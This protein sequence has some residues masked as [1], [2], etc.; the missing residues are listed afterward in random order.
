[1]LTSN[2]PPKG[3]RIDRIIHLENAGIGVLMFIGG[4]ALFSNT[5]A[6]PAYLFLSFLCLCFAAAGVLR[7]GHNLLKY[8]RSEEVL[9]DEPETKKDDDDE[10][11]NG[12]YRLH[13]K[14]MCNSA[15]QASSTI[16]AHSKKDAVMKFLHEWH[17]KNK[18]AIEID[19]VTLLN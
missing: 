6:E 2:S 18:P 11:I 7:I 19:R 17:I 14:Y 16:I 9:P 4:A 3:K 1:M 8:L 10:Y 12:E 13:Y 5:P 15:W